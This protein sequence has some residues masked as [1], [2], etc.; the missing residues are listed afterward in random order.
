MAQIRGVLGC[1]QQK[2]CECVLPR[3]P[4]AAWACA[5]RKRNTKNCR[6]LKSS[7]CHRRRRFP[8]L[9]EIFTV[10]QSSHRDLSIDTLSTFS[11]PQGFS[12]YTLTPPRWG[13]LTLAETTLCTYHGSVL[14]HIH[15]S[16]GTAPP[17]TAFRVGAE[18]VRRL[19]VS[20]YHT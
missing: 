18:R 14:L 6:L 5:F 20:D 7:S 8:I 19:P 1:S 4:H 9:R 15:H 17:A 13:P 16:C 10:L 11:T 3:A 12:D 2:W